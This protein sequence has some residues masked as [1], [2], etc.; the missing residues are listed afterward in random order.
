MRKSHDRL[1]F[2]GVAAGQNTKIPFELMIESPEQ[3]RHLLEHPL[4]LLSTLRSLQANLGDFGNELA[5]RFLEKKSVAGMA[6]KTFIEP[7]DIVSL[8]GIISSLN[9]DQR[10][11]ISDVLSVCQAKEKIARAPSQAIPMAVMPR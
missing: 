4:K 8:R 7:S 9:E 2:F 3:V 6:A 1:P 5:T 11:R 10:A